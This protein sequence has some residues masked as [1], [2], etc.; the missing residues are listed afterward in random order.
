MTTA[1]SRAAAAL[2]GRIVAILNSASGG[3]DPQAAART[4]AIFEAAGFTH[5]EVTDVSP[6]QVEGALGRAVTAAD[7]LVVLGGDGTIRSAAARCAGFAGFLMP[8]PGGTMNMLPHALY[9][10]RT[11]PQALA[12]TLANP[13]I[14]EV[15]GGQADGQP[16]FVAALLGSPTLW[17]DAREALR[18]GRLA[19]AF[20]RAVTAARRS[21]A[22]PLRYQ[23]GD[24]L[25]GAP[26]RLP[27]S[28]R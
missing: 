13:G 21:Y 22:E 3:W 17:A 8:L 11:W 4:R 23:F 24:T 1:D 26:K 27:W 18:A 2:K 14:H 12:D 15:S 9:G 20:Q 10:A 19:E 28:A 6:D 5:A 16:F 7:V 25:R